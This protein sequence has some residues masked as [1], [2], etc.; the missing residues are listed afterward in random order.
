MKFLFVFFMMVFCG[1]V[2]ANDQPCADIDGDGQ[3][4]IA[5][6]LILTE[7]YGQTTPCASAGKQTATPANPPQ[8]PAVLVFKIPRHAHKIFLQ[9]SIEP[10]VYDWDV[11]MLNAGMCPDLSAI[12]KLMAN[13]YRVEGVSVEIEYETNGTHRMPDGTVKVIPGRSYS[14]IPT[15]YGFQYED[16]TLDDCMYIEFPIKGRHDLGTGVE[17]V[18]KNNR[19]E[20]PMPFTLRFL[21]V[22]TNSIIQAY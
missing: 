1:A 2:H 17:F 16:G 12:R 5:D 19:Y 15:E 10:D 14:H 20:G 13:G 8:K 7:Q 18:D 3:V 6:F 11:K 21:M 22:H 4:N 9:W